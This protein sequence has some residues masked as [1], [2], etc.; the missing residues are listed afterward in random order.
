MDTRMPMTDTF[1]PEVANASPVDHAPATVSPDLPPEHPEVKPPKIAVLLVNLGTPDATD[2]WS[3]RRYLKEFLSDRRVIDVNRLIWWPLLNGII[4][5]TRPSKSGRAYASI[6]N[7]E[8]DESPLRTITRSQ[9]DRLAAELQTRYPNVTVDWAM[10]YG[11]PSLPD[12]ITRLQENGADRIVMLPLYPQYA[13]STTATVCDKA[14]DALKTLRWQPALRV[15]PA[16]H[17]HPAYINALAQS[18]RDHLATLDWTPQVILTSFHGVPKRYLMLGDPYHCHCAKTNR[19]MREA[20]G[21][22]KDTLRLTFQSRFGSEEWLQP[23]TDE[24]LE[25][26]PKEGITR[27]GIIAPGFSSD[28]LETLEELNVEGRESFME[29]GG[30][31]FTYIPCLN[32]SDAG[33]RV[34]SALIRRELAGWVEA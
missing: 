1:D 20:L 30:E 33:M 6:W 10:R 19:L 29:A 7:T 21:M 26:L 24:T 15:A 32:D 16:Y 4:L 8:R 31:K 12:V 11:N 2:Y 25:A 27:V 18:V 23:Y 13:A 3:M 9:S 28:C 34:I 14:F 5:T 17:D 22:D